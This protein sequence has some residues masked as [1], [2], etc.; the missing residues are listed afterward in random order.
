[1]ITC[2]SFTGREDRAT[3][4]SDLSALPGLQEAVC[5]SRCLFFFVGQMHCLLETKALNLGVR[6]RAPGRWILGYARFQ[7]IDAGAAVF[8]VLPG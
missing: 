1:M 3:L 6:G 2:K 7:R 4:R 8:I 5:K